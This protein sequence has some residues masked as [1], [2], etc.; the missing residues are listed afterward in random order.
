MVV[1]EVCRES[2]DRPWIT[3]AFD[4]ATRVVMGF[5]LSLR[6]PS[7]VSVGLALA[8]TGLPKEQWLAERSLETDWSMF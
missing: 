2:M 5:D 8:M 4:I 1:D 7:A 6:A 3:V